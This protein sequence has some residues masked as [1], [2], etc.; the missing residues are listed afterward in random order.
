LTKGSRKKRKKVKEERT[1]GGKKL[2]GDRVA[3]ESKIGLRKGEGER[4]NRRNITEAKKGREDNGPWGKKAEEVPPRKVKIGLNQ[5]N[6]KRVIN[7][8]LLS[9]K[10]GKTAQK[11]FQRKEGGET[12]LLK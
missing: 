10:K 4:G 6:R 7:R 2:S 12:R 11:C 5:G 9:E 1:D 3:L 8:P